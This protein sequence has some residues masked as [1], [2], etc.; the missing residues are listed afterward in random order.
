MATARTVREGPKP[1]GRTRT[2]RRRVRAPAKVAGSALWRAADEPEREELLLLDTHV[3]LWTLSGATERMAA[4]TVHLVHTAAGAGR[5]YV[6]DIS[7]WEV[8]LKTAKGKL[9]L[10]MD[11]ILWLERAARAPGIRALPITREL[12][13]QS[14]RLPGAMHGDPADRMLIAEAQLGGMSLLTCDD[15][16]IAYAAGVAG[17]R[18][19]DGR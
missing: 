12:L 1:Y 3:W 7:F 13:I 16:L 10:S 4:A 18:V 17:V 6:S 2:T 11:P 9:T 5:L 19:C 8:A 15:E 14:T